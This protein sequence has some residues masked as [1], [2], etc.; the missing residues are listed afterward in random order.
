MSDRGL[1]L[2]VT[3]MRDAEI[4]DLAIATFARLYRE[5]ESGA[6]GLIREADVEP[7]RDIDRAQDLDVSDEAARQAIGQTVVIKL[8]GGLGTSMGLAGPKSLL[9]VR[10]GLTFLDLIARQ[11]LATR[12]RYGASV[13]VVFMNSF[14]TRED[15]LATLERYP[16][17]AVDG[18]PLDFLQNREPKLDAET[19]EP[20]AWE[21]NPELEWCPPGHGDLYTALQT[22][23][24]LETLIERGYRYAS[25]SNADNLGAVPDAQIA[26]WFAASGAPYAAELVAKSDADVKGG[27]LVVRRSDGQIIQRETAQTLPE[28]LDV[29]ND[30]QVHPYFHANNLWFDL[31]QLRDLLAANDGVMPLPLIRNLK[32]V[33]PGDKSSPKVVQLETAMG[34]AVNVFPGAKV[35]EVERARFLPVKTTNDLLLLRSDVYDLTPQWHLVARLPAPLVSL[36]DRFTLIGDFE[37]RIEHVPSLLEADSLTVSGDWRFGDQVRVVGDGRLVA[38]DN[39]PHIVPPGSTVTADGVS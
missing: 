36:G 18:L 31:V 9:P 5:L 19:L 14:R 6:T 4:G 2:A 8:N 17:L 29:A 1:D 7:L 10:D 21:K 11:V 22:S 20:I 27:Q 32:T 38:G 16:D 26:A 3:K 23:G 15:T 35:I 28:E 25:V 30:R 13:P 24:L 12:E 37:T 33:D 39:E 34:A